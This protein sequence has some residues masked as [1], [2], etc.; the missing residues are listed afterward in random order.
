MN[1]YVRYKEEGSLRY[2][3]DT[4]LQF[5]SSWNVIGTVVMK[6][7]GS[8]NLSSKECEIREPDLLYHLQ[9]LTVMESEAPW[10]RF[11]EDKTMTCIKEIFE[12]FYGHELNGVIRIFN[13][14][15][16]MCA[17]FAEVK[18]LLRQGGVPCKYFCTVEHDIRAMVGPVYFGWGKA[19]KLCK[20]TADKYLE[21]G[22]RLNGRDGFQYQRLSDNKFYH[23][24]YL[25]RYGKGKVKVL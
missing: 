4:L 17:D 20:S 24:L 22:I 3:W 23:P 9:P 18:P 2:R 1:V 14:C 8:S 19:W 12:E 13:L 15:N 25:M 21:E 11:T 5:G 6:N 10:Y 7:P 16:V